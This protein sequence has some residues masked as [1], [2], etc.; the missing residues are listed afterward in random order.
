MKIKAVV[1]GVVMIVLGNGE[2]YPQ[3]KLSDSC[4][5]SSG[6]G[7][8]ERQ[9]GF[10]V[11]PRGLDCNPGTKSLP[12][13]TFQGAVEAVRAYKQSNDLPEDGLNV[14][15]RGGTY[16][17]ESSI[18]LG[19]LDN[20]N[21]H[22]PIIYR[23]Y[24][25]EQVILTGNGVLDEDMITLGDVSNVVI[26]N[27]TLRDGLQSAISTNHWSSSAV[28]LSQQENVVLDNLIV[29]GFHMDGIRLRGKNNT[30]KNCHIHDLGQRAVLLNGGDLDT[31]EPANNVLEN[32]RI[33]NTTTTRHIGRGGLGGSH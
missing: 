14:Y 18:S 7:P 4:A 10:F 16:L 12:K 17:I 15:F 11:A 19:E 5:T 22:T 3:P 30:I 9:D 8:K 29:R 23:N 32:T 20:G 13:A 31:L 6:L 26:M 33:E 1:I 24:P 2:A 21:P 28:E 25:G 27:M